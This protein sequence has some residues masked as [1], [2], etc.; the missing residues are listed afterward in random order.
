MVERSYPQNMAWIHT[1]V[2]EKTEFTD[3]A[4]RTDD[5]RLRYDSGSADKVKHS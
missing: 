3:Q 5:G 1:A 2:S 4:L